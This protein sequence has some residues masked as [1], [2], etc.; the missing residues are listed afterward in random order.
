MK[1]LS[2]L[3][4]I[5]VF[6]TACIAG[7]VHIQCWGPFHEARL[8]TTVQGIEQRGSVGCGENIIV[9]GEKESG[10]VKI[11]TIDKREGYVIAS[12]VSTEGPVA[13][14]G[15][16]LKIEQVMSAQE[17]QETGMYLLSS[18]QREAL[19]RWLVSYTVRL[20]ST[21]QGA[22]QQTSNSPPGRTTG[23]NCAPAIESTISG[24]FEGWEGETIFKLDN[25]QIWEQ[26]EYDYMYSYSYRPD[27]TIY[28]T[29]SG[30]RMK[31][32]DEEETI[33][34]RRIK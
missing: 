11:Q 7:D 34:V 8:F 2:T 28:Q 12:L 20:I 17:L 1:I 33:L 25:G 18:Q 10:R 29:S 31:V 4:C 19:N 14:Q 24:D 32:E 27:V 23:S 26:S 6:S 21:A 30:C 22:N 3:P 13:A 5:I 16:L 9:L 15:S